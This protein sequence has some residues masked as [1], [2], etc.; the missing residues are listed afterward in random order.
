[1]HFEVKVRNAQAAGAA[2]VVVFNEGQPG[3]DGPF[4]GSGDTTGIDI[5]V[6]FVAF[7]V[8]EDLYSYQ[9]RRA[10]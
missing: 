5:P 7:D 8:G 1:M 2:G 9:P 4:S 6:V 10:R 3:R